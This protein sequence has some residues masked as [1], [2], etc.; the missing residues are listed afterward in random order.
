MGSP[1]GHGGSECPFPRVSSLILAIGKVAS[2]VT[3]G[4]PG[5][6]TMSLSIP[7]PPRAEGTLL[8]SICRETELPGEEDL[9]VGL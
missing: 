3:R 6:L 7:D 4:S 2:E 5:C 1:E 9:E 8:V